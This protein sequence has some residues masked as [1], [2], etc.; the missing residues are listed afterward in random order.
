MIC[1]LVKNVRRI[2]KE[3]E[4]FNQ[5]LGDLFISS[6][7]EWSSQVLDVDSPSSLNFLDYFYYAWLS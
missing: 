5:R 2:F 3:E 4:L 6:L 7:V 1:F